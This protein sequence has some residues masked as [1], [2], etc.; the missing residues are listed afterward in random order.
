MKYIII[1][2]IISFLLFCRIASTPINQYI[3]PVHTKIEVEL[4][5]KLN[6]TPEPINEPIKIAIP[7]IRE[8]TY[9]EIHKF[10]NNLPNCSWCSACGSYARYTHLEAEKQ[11]INIKEYRIKAPVDK[12]MVAGHQLNYF[13]ADDGHRVYIDNTNNQ[14]DIIEPSELKQYILNRY[15]MIIWD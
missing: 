4:P 10:L 2:V 14:K 8:E 3:Y 7:K 1:G 13:I 11:G 9:P 15:G 12:N 5:I 6:F